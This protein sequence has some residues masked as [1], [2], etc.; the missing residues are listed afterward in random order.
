M[1]KAGL[2]VLG[3][4]VAMSGVLL[5][6][7]P[8]TSAQ[9]INR[10]PTAV[11]DVVTVDADGAVSSPVATCAFQS[12]TTT[13]ISVQRNVESVERTVTSGCVAGPPPFVPGVR[14][15]TFVDTVLVTVTTT[16]RSRGRRGPVYDVTTTTTREILSSQLV[17]STCEAL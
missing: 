4:A 6:G 10:L 7:A 16:V 2:S 13:C 5:V 11:P 8:A 14:R 12:G 17:S 15:Q 9:E 3:A 1:R